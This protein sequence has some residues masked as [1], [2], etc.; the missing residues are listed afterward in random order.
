M[1]QVLGLKILVSGLV[2]IAVNLTVLFIK[3]AEIAGMELSLQFA[4]YIIIA[5]DLLIVLFFTSPLWRFVWRLPWI[6]SYLSENVFPDLNGQYAVTIYTNWP[7]VNS[8]Y[9][10]ACKTG[11]FTLDDLSGGDQDC[12]KQQLR[13]EIRQNWFRFF[14]RFY[15]SPDD[16][17][18]NVIR[19]S[20][21]LACMPLKRDGDRR[22]CLAYL[23]EQQNAKQGKLDDHSFKGA[24]QLEIYSDKTLK[25]DYWSNRAWRKGLNTAGRIEFV[26]IQ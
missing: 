4:K 24:A 5:V 15:P 20:T 19:E 18:R 25:G 6:G 7:I 16:D 26:R 23:F 2:V 3:G 9:Q 13:A 21:T 17:D 14:I 8:M 10:A 22:P 12:N 1:Y 11:G